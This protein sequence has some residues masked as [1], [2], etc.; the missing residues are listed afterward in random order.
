MRKQLWTELFGSK[1]SPGL[2]RL[3]QEAAEAGD[4]VAFAREK[5]G[6]NP[7]E[8]QMAMLLGGKRG[9]LNCARQW[10]KSTVAAAKAVHRAYSQAG[11]LTL[12]LSPSGRQSGGFIRKSDE[13]VRRRGVRRK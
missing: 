5:L 2:A 1:T 10:G 7:D 6:F 12:L 8:K 4:A 11:S 13:F 3:R 9:I